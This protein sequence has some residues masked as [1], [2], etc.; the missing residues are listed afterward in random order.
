MQTV[1]VTGTDT[2]VGKTYVTCLLVRKLQATGLTVG[3]YKPV[4]SGAEKDTVGRPFWPDIDALRSAAGQQFSLDLICPQR[5]LA[6]VAPNIAAEMEGSVVSDDLLLSGVSAWRTE[7]DSLIVEGAGGIFCPLSN[8][9]TVLD[10]ATQLQAPIVVVAANRLGVINHTR[11]TV[12]QIRH[13]GLEVAAVIL[14]E[15]QQSD[16][17]DGSLTTNARQISHWIPD[18]TLLH[19]PFRSDRIAIL[20]QARAL[21]NPVLARILKG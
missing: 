9:V 21:K 17:D 5:F 6:A 3:A 20:H 11:L 4:C 19:L 18:V 1:F 16:A 7:V 14:N 13:S 12:E 15:H 10:L 2:N 8:T